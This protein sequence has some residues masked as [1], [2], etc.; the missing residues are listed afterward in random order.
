MVAGT[1]CLAYSSAS[2]SGNQ[3]IPFNC[4]I[5]YFI[6]FGIVCSQE[7][8]QLFSLINSSW[9]TVQQETVLAVICQ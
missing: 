4:Y 3:F 1:A 5:Q 7:F 8:I 6:N 9:E 2:Q